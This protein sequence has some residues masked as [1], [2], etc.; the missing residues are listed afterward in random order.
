MLYTNFVLAQMGT[1]AANTGIFDSSFNNRKINF[2]GL[3]GIARQD[4]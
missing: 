4:S 2:A 1:S 3:I